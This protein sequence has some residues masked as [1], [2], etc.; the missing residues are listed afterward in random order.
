MTKWGKRNIPLEDTAYFSASFHGKSSQE[1]SADVVSPSYLQS[2]HYTTLYK[3][4]LVSAILSLSRSQTSS[5]LLKP[6]ATFVQTSL[7]FWAAGT[8]PDNHLTHFSLQLFWCFS[9]FFSTWP[10]NIGIFQSLASSL[11]SPPGTLSLTQQYQLPWIL[12]PW[13]WRGANSLLQAGSLFW[14]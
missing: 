12:R 7:S 4:A 11:F 3:M 6:M 10:Q 2:I 13:C 5:L 14:N 8:Q 1:C 9:S